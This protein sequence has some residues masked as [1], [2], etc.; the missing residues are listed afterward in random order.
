MRMFLLPWAVACSAMSHEPPL[1]ATM[2]PVYCPETETIAIRI[3][4][5]SDCAWVS[6][7]AAERLGTAGQW[8]E[9]SADLL[10]KE[11]F[12]R[13]VTTFQLE[14]SKSRLIEWRP[15][16]T[17]NSFG[18]VSGRYRVVSHSLAKGQPPARQDVLVEFTA[19]PEA[20]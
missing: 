12:P 20:C 9:Y 4:N 5:V 7:I 2:D 6:S 15:R 17:G 16:T 1:K 8:E 18:L 14:P 13:K 19:A 3:E 11:A 10:G